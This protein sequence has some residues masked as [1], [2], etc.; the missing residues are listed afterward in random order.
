MANLMAQMAELDPNE[1]EEFVRENVTRPLMSTLSMATILDDP[2]L[3]SDKT[4]IH[5]LVQIQRAS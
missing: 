1:Q 2:K 3:Q 4:S 5:S